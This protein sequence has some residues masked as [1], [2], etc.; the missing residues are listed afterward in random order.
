MNEIVHDKTVLIIDDGMCMWLAE[1]LARDFMTVYL[2]TSWSSDYPQKKDDV[3]GEG[4]PNVIRLSDW[5]PYLD[6]IDVFIFPGLYQGGLQQH[7]VNLGKNVWG[8]KY[9]DEYERQ[10]WESHKLFD[11]MGIPT[12]TIKKITGFDKLVDHLKNNNDKYIKISDYRGDGETWLHKEFLLSEQDL[13]RW[14][15]KLGKG[16][17]NYEFLVEDPINGDDTVETGF[18]PYVI[19]GKLPSKVLFGYEVKDECY[20]SHVKNTADLPSFITDFH[21]KMVDELDKHEYRNFLSTEIRVGKDKIP[22]VIDVTTRFPSPP[23][24][25]YAEMCLNFSEIFYYGAQG[26]LIDPIFEFEYGLEVFIYSHQAENEWMPIKFPAEIARWVKLRNYTIIDGVYH[27][28]PKYPN[29]DNVGALVTMG[30]SLK[31]CFNKIKELKDQIEGQKIEIHIGSIDELNE[32]IKKG[33]NIG[34]NF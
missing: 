1:R 15:H 7:L 6:K 8:S 5:W 14:H 9:G 21:E 16:R 4:I 31:E 3:I 24:E 12:A 30:K 2:H 34:I 29:F 26:I 28:I 27:V 10:R 33:E 32:V 23:S 11:K 22:Y 18:D 19:D 25:L 20:G 13:S 17:D